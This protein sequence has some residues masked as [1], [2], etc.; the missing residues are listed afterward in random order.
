[1]ENLYDKV[2]KL[3]AEILKKSWKPD[4]GTVSPFSSGSSINENPISDNHLEYYVKEDS[5][6]PLDGAIADIF[7][8]NFWTNGGEKMTEKTLDVETSK[9]EQSQYEN[10]G[11]STTEP[12]PQSEIAITKMDR[13]KDSQDEDGKGTYS[14]TA[15]TTTQAPDAGETTEPVAKA[16]SCQDCGK[17]MDMCMCKRA[18]C[19]HCGQSMPDEMNKA[20]DG[21]DAEND[22][23]DDDKME[24]KEFSSERREELADQGKAMPDGSFPIESEQD[25]RN[26]IQAYGRAKNKDAAKA[27]II[28]RAKALGKTNLLP[29]DWTSSVKKSLWGGSFSPNIKRGF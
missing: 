2:V 22:G 25:L 26:A 27:H 10:P 20:E 16:D 18:K 12:D 21:K 4:S 29:K 23:D 13:P 6:S 15:N 19:P 28:S 1:M 5:K 8:S 24:K 3:T 9:T 7:N 11:E 14:T 17:E